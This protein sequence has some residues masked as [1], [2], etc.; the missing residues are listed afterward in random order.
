MIPFWLLAGLLAVFVLG[1]ILL[2][3]RHGPFDRAA[4]AGVIAAVA[5]PV[6]AIVLY[7]GMGQPG[8]PDLPLSARGPELEQAR[9]VAKVRAAVDKLAAV[10]AQKQTDPRAWS[11][12][13]DGYWR[14]GA[15]AEAAEAFGKAHDLSPD[16]PTMAL[17]HAEALVRSE[18]GLVTPP[19]ARLFKSV[20]AADPANPRAR[21]FD[22]LT[23]AQ[24]GHADEALSVWEALAEE[25]AE[26][27]PWRAALLD[28]IARLRA[29]KE[30]G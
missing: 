25:T 11:M 6:V 15:Y 24:A 28:N 1:M 12:V 4:I 5:V 30:A 17:A 16:D 21:L 22:G 18:D 13:A 8:R 14:L 23:H 29:G 10:A 7:A 19:A 3:L 9:Q 20:L 2:P 26:D 27:V